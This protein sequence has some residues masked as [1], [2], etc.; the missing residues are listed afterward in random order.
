M[1]ARG[2]P[3][4]A[5]ERN[6]RHTEAGQGV[7]AV[8]VHGA[9]AADAL[10]TAPAKGQGRVDLVL[11]ADD[12]IEHHG[13]GLVEVNG[14]ALEPRLLGRR[15]GVPAV[16]LERLQARLLLLDLADRGHGATR[17]GHAGAE[18]RRPGGAEDSRRVAKS[19]HCL[20]FRGSG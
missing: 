11:D 7:L 6:K 14:V 4:S 1:I 8:D 20:F 16:D 13:A 5:R 18:S 3:I 17:K 9:R 12:G 2:C 15:V 10:A 19:C